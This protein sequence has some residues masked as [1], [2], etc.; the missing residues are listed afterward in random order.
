VNDPTKEGQSCRV[1]RTLEAP[2][3]LAK[4]T[5]LPSIGPEDVLRT[6]SRIGFLRKTLNEVLGQSESLQNRKRGSQG[7]APQMCF[8]EGAGRE[9]NLL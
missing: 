7:P 6:G 4:P 3:S 2:T 8:V 1:T 9:S 5:R